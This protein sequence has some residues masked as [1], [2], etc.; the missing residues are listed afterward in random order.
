MK[1]KKKSFCLYNFF[2]PHTIYRENTGT[3]S[4]I[5]KLKKHHQNSKS[6]KVRSHYQTRASDYDKRNCFLF[7]AS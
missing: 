1:M 4:Q 7:V 2:K 5:H 6:L 3:L